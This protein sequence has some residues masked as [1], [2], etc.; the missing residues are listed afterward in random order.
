M[1]KDINFVQNRRKKLTKDQKKD[2]QIF[3]I[4]VGTFGVL[5]AVFFITLGIDFYLK[6][7]VKKAQDQQRE[8]ER[9]VLAQEPIEQSIVIATEK[10][11]ILSELFDQR[12]DKQ[13]AIDYFSNIFGPQV[14]IKDINY[15]ADERILSLRLQSQSIFVLE[16]VFLKL[17]DP[18]VDE[19]FG[20]V[21]KSELIRNDRGGYNMAITL[22]LSEE[23][24]PKK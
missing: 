22:S 5:L 10:L 13:A 20:N 15:E 19:Q 3:K 6:F 7:Q 24:L 2:F 18:T 17:S 8:M 16:E 21:N 1:A 23:D 12:Y 4:V 11:K 9:Q 14:L